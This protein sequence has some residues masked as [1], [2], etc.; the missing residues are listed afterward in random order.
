[1]LFQFDY[2]KAMMTYLTEKY[3]DDT[4]HFI[5]IGTEVL[6]SSYVEMIAS[7][8]KFP[9]PEYYIHVRMTRKTHEITENYIEFYFREQTIAHVRPLI[10]SVYGPC[11][12][13]SGISGTDYF[14][15]DL[16]PD[17][18]ISEYLRNV[19]NTPYCML[20]FSIHTTKDPT[21]RDEDL[22]SLRQALAS[23]EYRFGLSIS[24]VKKLNED[25]DKL[26]GI[27]G[28]QWMLENCILLGVFT[29]DDNYMFKSQN[30][31]EYI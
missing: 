18:E 12:I 4:F 10:E 26:N 21:S 27:Q 29:M 30:W 19:K 24:Y 20:D 5:N 11:R 17:M 9:N 28:R 1:M 3:P 15:S 13:R 14:L 22:E 25:L 23:Q 2:K 31:R 6:G 8:D 16:R 7:S